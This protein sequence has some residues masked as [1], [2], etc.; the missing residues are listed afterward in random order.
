MRAVSYA[1][2]GLLQGAFWP[3]SQLPPLISVYHTAVSVIRNKN[4]V[5]TFYR[6]AAIFCFRE[7]S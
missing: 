6:V 3:M 2:Q 1:S 5:F 4:G 7:R